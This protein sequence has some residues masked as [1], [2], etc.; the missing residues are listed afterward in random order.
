[1]F[2]HLIKAETLRNIIWS[3]IL[4]NTVETDLCSFSLFTCV[5]LEG[6]TGKINK[7]IRVL[8]MAE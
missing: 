2:R 6:V 8:V 4:L 5:W 7:I 3:R 1:M